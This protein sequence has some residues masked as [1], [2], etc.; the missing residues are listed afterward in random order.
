MSASGFAKLRRGLLDHYSSMSD[1]ENKLFTYAV[2]RARNVGPKAG[3]FA[4]TFREIAA[5]LG[6]SR[7]KLSRVVEGMGRYLAVETSANQHAQST[8][9]I[10]NFVGSGVPSAGQHRDS[11]GTAPGQQSQKTGQHRDSTGTAKPKNG[12]APAVIDSEQKTSEPGRRVEKVETVEKGETVE[13]SSNDDGGAF[14]TWYETY[15]RKVGKV[16]GRKAFQAVIV[17][18][19]LPAGAVAEDMDGLKGPDA[20]FDRLMDTSAA[21]AAE[22]ERRDADKRPHPATFINS[23]NW[24]KPPEVAIATRNTAIAVGGNWNGKPTAEQIQQR[25]R[26]RI[27]QEAE[28]W[29]LKRGLDLPSS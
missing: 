23:L 17:N 10:V 8:F 15:P 19:R 18:G 24:I 25:D 20:R 3:Q 11:T 7:T 16:Q 4:G 14:E 6:W 9:T 1:A 29:L 22:F 2:L 26:A 12:T 28:Q 13:T 27:T 5:D 21:W